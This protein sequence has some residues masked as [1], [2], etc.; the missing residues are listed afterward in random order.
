MLLSPSREELDLAWARVQEACAAMGLALSRAKSGS[1]ALGA[2][3]PAAWPQCP[4]R[5]GPLELDATGAWVVSDHALA[6][7]IDLARAKVGEA[8]SAL[9]A[10]YAYN[11][12]VRRLVAA[13]VPSLALGE[14]HTQKVG[15]A[16]ARFH[17]DVFAL[18]EPRVAALAG[19]DLARRLP[20]AWFHWPLTAGGLGLVDPWVELA[21]YA[22][23]EPVDVPGATDAP[24]AD[25]EIK[26]NAYGVYYLKL[27]ETLTPRTPDHN[28]RYDGLARDF[29]KRKAEMK[30]QATDGELAP[31]WQWVLSTH[32]ADVLDA[33]GTYRFLLHELLPIHLLRSGRQPARQ[34]GDGDDMPS[35]APEDDIPF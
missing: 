12:H 6:Q 17:A 16:L 27:L 28:P 30:G 34:Q 26:K 5:V 29:I 18:L 7:A 19:D 31:Y 22:A 2:E 35:R 11:T 14:G 4:F 13:L 10:A 25:V 32:G 21:P 15:A 33:F 20:R 24:W 23:P 9:E 1:F 8:R 3:R